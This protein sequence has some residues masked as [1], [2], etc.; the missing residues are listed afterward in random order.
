MIRFKLQNKSIL[1]IFIWF[2]K[3]KFYEYFN[4]FQ[5]SNTELKRAVSLFLL[6]SENYY[7][8]TYV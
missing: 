5:I 3:I 4:V 2:Y 6:V 7:I 8:F 1:V